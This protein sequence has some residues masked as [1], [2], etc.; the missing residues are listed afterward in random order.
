MVKELKAIENNKI[1]NLCDIPPRMKLISVKWVFRTK[2]TPNGEILKHK[3]RLVAR[4]Y[5]QE[6]GIDYEDIFA[7]V[8]RMETVRIMFT[9]ATQNNWPIF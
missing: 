6:Y 8:A 9:L 3:A 7:P 4:G 5:S 1:W 2:Y